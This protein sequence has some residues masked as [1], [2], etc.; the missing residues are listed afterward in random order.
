MNG[1]ELLALLTAMGHPQRLRIIAELTGGRVHV[2]A[3]ARQL[4]LSR[5]LLYLHLDRLRTAGLINSH[6][7]LSDDGTARNYIQL[8]P[9]ELNLTADAVR[10]A[11][12]TDDK[13]AQT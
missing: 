5:P 12:G 9:F 2:S 10:A 6:T 11:L 13:E 7:E 1:S 4:G 8:T 3:L